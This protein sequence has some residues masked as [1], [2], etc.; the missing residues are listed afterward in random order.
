MN[1]WSVTCIMFAAFF[2]IIALV[3]AVLKD[4]G[5]SLISGFNTLSKEEMAKYDK[6]K[7]SADMRNS[8]FIWSVILLLGGILTYLISN[9]FAIL[10]IIIWIVLFL[11]DV[12]IDSE[13]AF[14]KYIK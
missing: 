11:K 8:F 3:F 5:A 13:K 2:A 9:Y 1:V 7:M 6:V 4:R 14:V 12:H 10:A